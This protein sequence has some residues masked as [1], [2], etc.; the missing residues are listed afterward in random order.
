M[1]VKLSMKQ[2]ERARLSEHELKRCRAEARGQPWQ[3]WEEDILWWSLDRQ[4]WLPVDDAQWPRRRRWLMVET[5]EGVLPALLWDVS[6]GLGLPQ[7]ED[8]SPFLRRRLPE[9]AAE[10]F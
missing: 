3:V 4:S 7:H 5:E 10:V 9:N 1:Q 2:V 6:E 8:D